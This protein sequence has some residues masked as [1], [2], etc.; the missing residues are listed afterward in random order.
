VYKNLR[1]DLTERNCN[2]KKKTLEDFIHEER[3]EPFITTKDEYLLFKRVLKEM[4]LPSKEWE[5]ILERTALKAREEAIVLIK[6]NA[7]EQMTRKKSH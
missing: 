1:F 4:I 7:E 3:V 5:G 2:G 6:K